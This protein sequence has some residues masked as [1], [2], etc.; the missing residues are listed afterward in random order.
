VAVQRPG[1]FAVE[2]AVR[3]RG[4]FEHGALLG[5][6]VVRGAEAR[7]VGAVAVGVG[8]VHRVQER[9]PQARPAERLLGSGGGA[10]L[11]VEAPG[12]Q[13]GGAPEQVGRDLRKRLVALGPARPRRHEERLGPRL[14]AD[15]AQR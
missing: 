1:A 11:G 3:V 10:V 13:V 7:P 8:R 9:A 6:E 2:L 15:A 4:A 5:D 12:A 14:A